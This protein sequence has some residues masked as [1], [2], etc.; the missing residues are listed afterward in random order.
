M[1]AKERIFFQQNI[2]KLIQQNIKIEFLK[3]NNSQKEE[4]NVDKL[5]K[6]F[7]E[8]IINLFK[9]YNEEWKKNIKLEIDEKI[10]QQNQIFNDQYTQLRE[11][12]KYLKKVQEEFYD[13]LNNKEEKEIV[14][15]IENKQTIKELDES[16][17]IEKVRYLI[18]KEIRLYEADHTGMPDYA[19]ESSGGSVLSTRCTVQYNEKSRTQKLFGI[20][21]WYTS[22]SPRT[23]IQR[24]GYGASAGECWAFYGG[25]GFLTIGL[26]GRINVTAVSYEHL[27]I[28]LSPDGNIRTAPKNF[29][30][31][32]YQDMDNMLSRT[33]LGNFTYDAQG[34]PLQIFHVQHWDSRLTNIIELETLTN[35]GSYLTCLYR[36]RVHG[37]AL[38]IIPDISEE[39]D[40]AK[41]KR[42]FSNNPVKLDE[43]DL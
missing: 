10:D 28:E 16:S 18:K 15:I 19:L 26:S 43:G 1:F 9:K 42:L 6:D 25:H 41:A 36:F 35:W 12:I 39:T 11:E 4:K 23:V 33:L 37:D 20:P 30:V 29:L 2:H 22:Y 38:K 17:L 5:L 13:K 8:K 21:L 27:P 31:W 24:K 7:E 32:S 3:L 34:E 40:D 14:K